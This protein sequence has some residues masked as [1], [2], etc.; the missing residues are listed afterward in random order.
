M[1]AESLWRPGPDARQGYQAL[2]LLD[3]RR[4]GRWDGRRGAIGELVNW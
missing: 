3:I 2:I 4:P 1:D